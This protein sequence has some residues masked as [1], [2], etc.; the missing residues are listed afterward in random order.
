MKNTFL[1]FCIS[2]LV[3]LF[4]GCS[5]NSDGEGDSTAINIP[6]PNITDIDGNTYQSV[7]IG[8]QTWIKQN[9]NVSKYSDG[10][11]IPEVSDPIEW[12]NLTTGAWCYYN[13]DPAY[14]PIYGKLYNWYAVAGIYDED[15]AY[16]TTL[17]KKLAPI[18]W[19]IPSNSECV[20]ESEWT[21]LINFL[22]GNYVAGGKIKEEGT[23]HWQ[24]PNSASNISGFTALPGGYRVNFGAFESIT[25]RAGFWTSSES[26]FDSAWFH[27]LYN[28]YVFIQEES[29]DKKIGYSVRCVKD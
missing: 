23:L 11:L 18:G 28:D 25:N 14:G 10:T 16:D 5:T 12:N 27:T 1:Q 17:R 19:H 9:L 21:Q 3:V 22:G 4:F 7:I 24:S 26:D 15:S 8:S 6:G 13:N 29:N 20:C 2:V